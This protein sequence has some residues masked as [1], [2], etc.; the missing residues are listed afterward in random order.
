MMSQET[1]ATD[2]VLEQIRKFQPQ[3]KLKLELIDDL[4][5]YVPTTTSQ[6]A[7]AYWSKLLRIE[8]KMALLVHFTF[9]LHAFCCSIHDAAMMTKCYNCLV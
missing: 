1:F 4:C 5:S 7:T 2:L 8:F 6:R 3:L 9:G